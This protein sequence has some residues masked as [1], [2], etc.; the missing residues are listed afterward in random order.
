MPFSSQR[1]RRW[2]YANE[3][4]MARRWEKKTPKGKPLPKKARKKK[5]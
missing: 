4:E 3:P 5:R 2:M 1:Q